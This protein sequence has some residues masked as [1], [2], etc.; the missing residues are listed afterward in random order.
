MRRLLIVLMAMPSAVALVAAGAAK[1][2]WRGP[3]GG[4]STKPL[5]AVATTAAAAPVPP[6]PSEAVRS[7]DGLDSDD[8][9]RPISRIPSEVG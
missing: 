4:V 6:R 2:A 9:L 8:P 3:S 5:L 7:R 1:P